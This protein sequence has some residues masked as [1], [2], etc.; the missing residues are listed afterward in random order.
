MSFIQRIECIKMNILPGILFL[1]Q[2]LPVEINAKQFTEWDKILW[3]FIWQGKKP[4]VRFKT[5]QLPKKEGGMAIPH[6]KDYFYSTQIRPLLNLCD[7]DYCARWGDIEKTLIKDLQ[8]QAVLGNKE[9]D[10]IIN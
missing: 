8:I 9:V 2:A 3:R 10:Q 7:Q 6:L 1:F 5:L 4:R